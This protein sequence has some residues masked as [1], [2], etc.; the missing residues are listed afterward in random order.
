MDKIDIQKNIYDLE[1]QS[2]LNMQNIVF[3]IIAAIIIAVLFTTELPSNLPSKSNIF[4]L[5]SFIA[6]LFFFYFKGE[7]RRKIDNIKN[8]NKEIS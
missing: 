2:L 6:V 5:L 1:Y 3:G 8:I 4:S 7:L